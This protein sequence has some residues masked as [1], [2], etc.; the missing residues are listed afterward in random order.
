MVTR[1]LGRWGQQ[2]V[3]GALGVLGLC[4]QDMGPYLFNYV[5]M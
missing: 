3:S 4:A 1:W 5:S 2:V